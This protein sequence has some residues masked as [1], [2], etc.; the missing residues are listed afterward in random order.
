MTAF[1]DWDVQKG[2]Y[3][4]LVAQGTLTG[5]LAAGAAS[6]RDHVLPDAA[7]PYVV[8]GE[9]ESRPQSTQ[10]LP[11]REVVLTLHAFSQ[12]P[13][14]KEVREILSALHDALEDAALSIEGQ[15]VI[16]CRSLSARSFLEGDGETRHGVFQVEILTEPA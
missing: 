3:A 11:G 5:L 13:G 10:Q 4:H 15:H 16:S 9:I 14:Q 8:I 6:V 1:C 2:V 12:A 7:F